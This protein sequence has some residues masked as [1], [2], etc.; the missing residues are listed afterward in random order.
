MPGISSLSMGADYSFL[1]FVFLIYLFPVGSIF[2][3]TLELFLLMI[4][5]ERLVILDCP[6]CHGLFRKLA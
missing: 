5:L 6:F 2:W 3:F 4:F 1:V